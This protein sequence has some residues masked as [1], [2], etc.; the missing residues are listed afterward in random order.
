[1]RK[2]DISIMALAAV[3][4]SPLFATTLPLGASTTQLNFAAGGALT[5]V[6]CSTVFCELSSTGPVT[7]DA[8]PISWAVSL[9]LP[10]HMLTLNGNPQF[11]TN[12]GNIEMDSGSG[13]LT[14]TDGTLGDY[15]QANATGG[16]WTSNS[17]LTVLSF[18]MS[19]SEASVSSAPGIF[20]I[21]ETLGG[22]PV[23]GTIEQFNLDVTCPAQCVTSTDPVG[24]IVSGSFGAVPT[25]ATPE[26]SLMIL[27][28]VGFAS[29]LFARGC[30]R[31]RRL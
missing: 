13:L 4:A 25:T 16:T 7:I 15:I 17:S 31:L 28:A 8:V 11:S 12:S 18:S 14:V 23:S 24:T 30:S 19:I 27:L 22:I 5:V 6:G 2:I 3:L 10:N 9:D 26:P 29:L 21:D 20:L 1:M